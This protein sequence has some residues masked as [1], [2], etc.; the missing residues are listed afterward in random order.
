MT[1]TFSVEN[2]MLR[3]I[4][5]DLFSLN[6]AEFTIIIA[7]LYSNADQGHLRVN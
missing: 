4:I 6:N 1:Q 2:G 7:C 5:T 3:L